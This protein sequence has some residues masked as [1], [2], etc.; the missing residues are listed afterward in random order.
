M[1]WN[2]KKLPNALIMFHLEPSLFRSHQSLIDVKRPP[3]QPNIRQQLALLKYRVR[4]H[5]VVYRNYLSKWKVFLRKGCRIGKIFYK[6][7]KKRK[8]L[9]KRNTLIALFMV[10]PVLFTASLSVASARAP[11][12]TFWRDHA[13]LVFYKHSCVHCQQFGP[14]L[15]KTV[16]QMQLPVI[17]FTLDG[18]LDTNYNDTIAVYPFI[19]QQLMQL[20]NSGAM[21]PAATLLGKLVQGRGVNLPAIFLV[22]KDGRVWQVSSGPQRVDQFIHQLLVAMQGMHEMEDNDG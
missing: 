17:T 3:E 2:F 6:G 11:Q 13:M 14:V 1:K 7:K 18:N 4:L 21:N 9:K 19:F 10:I 12:I 15:K 20:K 8:K 22:S 16:M 5:Y